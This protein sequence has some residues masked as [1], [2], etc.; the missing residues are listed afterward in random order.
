ML[1]AR[2]KIQT[3]NYGNSIKEADKIE[4]INM[5]L[6]ELQCKSNINKFFVPNATHYELSHPYADDKVKNPYLRTDDNNTDL[7]E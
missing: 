1:L 4:I 2:D 6:S 3:E 7:S 5:L